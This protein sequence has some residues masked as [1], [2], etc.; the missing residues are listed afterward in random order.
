MTVGAAFGDPKKEE[1]VSFGKV[2]KD[3]FA[4][5]AGE[6]GAAKVDAT[7]FDEANK[8]LDELSK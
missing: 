6:P 3:V 7:D 8:L 4:S 5:R 2:E 1:R